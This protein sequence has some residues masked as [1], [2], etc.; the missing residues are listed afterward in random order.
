M[1]NSSALGSLAIGRA[2]KKA[3][4]L[5]ADIIFFDEVGWSFQERVTHTWAPR[6]KPPVLRRKSQRR[7]LSS[8]VG[9]SISGKIYKRHFRRAIDGELIIEVLKHIHRQVGGRFILIWDRAPTHRAQVVS[10]YLS[11]QPEIY[12]E[13]LPAYAPELNPEEYCHGNVK[14]RIRNSAPQSVAEM[15]TLVDRG[16][17]RLR[18]RPD[19][20]LGFFH[21]AGLTV[22][23]LW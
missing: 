9:L 7:E 19:L 18:Q 16:F 5:R 15:Q 17:A 13:W 11:N 21:H 10:Q 1:K 4:R 2:S 6:G 23:Q 14:E 8:A 22:K 12:P 3:R 20:L